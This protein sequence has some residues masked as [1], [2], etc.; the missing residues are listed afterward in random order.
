MGTQVGSV[1]SSED[2]RGAENDD[3]VAESS[4]HS[5]VNPAPVRLSDLA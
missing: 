1:G 5:S 3:S 2:E 4:D